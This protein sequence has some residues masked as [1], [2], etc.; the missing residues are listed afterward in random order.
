MKLNSEC[1]GMY[2]ANFAVCRDFA[3]WR[4]VL[5]FISFSFLCPFTVTNIVRDFAHVAK[6]KNE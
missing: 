5:F 2:I 6:T 1:L 3:Q 4:C